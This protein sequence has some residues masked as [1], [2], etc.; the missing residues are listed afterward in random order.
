MKCILAKNPFYALDPSSNNSKRKVQ[1]KLDQSKNNLTQVNIK[2]E[3]KEFKTSSLGD[4]ENNIQTQ[5]EKKVQQIA[6]KKI[7]FEDLLK[8]A[9]ERARFESG[10]FSEAFPE[11]ILPNLILPVSHERS[12]VPEN[13]KWLGEVL[14]KFDENQV[15]PEELWGL[16]GGKLVQSEDDLLFVIKRALLKG[17]EFPLWRL[18]PRIVEGFFQ[19]NEAGDSLKIANLLKVAER[20]G[21]SRFLKQIRE[22]KYHLLFSSEL[23]TVSDSRTPTGFSFAIKVKT[24]ERFAYEVALKTG[25]LFNRFQKW[26]LEH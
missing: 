3:H 9:I 26:F 4:S 17:P 16:T 2:S 10:R 25:I 7:K 14:D 22:K 24:P 20:E 15:T 18:V 11:G 6:I 12:L 21:L 1:I 23:I 8:I 13:I 5:L 19:F